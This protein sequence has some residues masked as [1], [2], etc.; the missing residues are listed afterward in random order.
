M[1]RTEKVIGKLEAN[2]DRIEEIIKRNKNNK[3]K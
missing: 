3:D 2:K 1:V